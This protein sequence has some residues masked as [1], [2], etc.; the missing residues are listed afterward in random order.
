MKDNKIKATVIV[1]AFHVSE[2]LEYYEL[3]AHFVIYPTLI[4]VDA[5]SDVLQ[6]RHHAQRK[7]HIKELKHILKEA[8]AL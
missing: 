4:A 6:N 1:T 3:G 5:V 2:A 8:H 7:T